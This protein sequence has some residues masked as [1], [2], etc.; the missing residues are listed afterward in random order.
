MSR[1]F[2]HIYDLEHLPDRE[3]SDFASIDQARHHAVVTA[4]EMI[5]EHGGGWT[6]EPWR[7]TVVDGAGSV[8]CR[9][10]FTVE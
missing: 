2:F 6:D 1:F 8:V 7:I 5:R 10:S 3:G 9:L 4:G